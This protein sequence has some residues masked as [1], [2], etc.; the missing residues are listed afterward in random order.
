MFMLCFYFHVIS[1]ER[2]LRFQDAALNNKKTTLSIASTISSHFQSC[3]LTWHPGQ[4]VQGPFKKCE[5]YS[6]NLSS[7]CKDYHYLWQRPHSEP[8]VLNRGLITFTLLSCMLRLS[9]K[10]P[11]LDVTWFP[12][13]PYSPAASPEQPGVWGKEEKGSCHRAKIQPKGPTSPQAQTHFLPIFSV[14][15]STLGSALQKCWAFFCL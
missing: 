6:A 8:L 3:F 12:S 13:R 5:M 2:K 15:T 14:S 11:G 10:V 1:S 7:H 9:R 4:Y